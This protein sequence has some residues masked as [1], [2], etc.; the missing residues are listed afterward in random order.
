M[1]TLSLLFFAWMACE[2]DYRDM[3]KGHIDLVNV[4]SS[5]DGTIHAK[6]TFKAKGDGYFLSSGKFLSSLVSKRT[7]AI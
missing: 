1:S 7:H 5:A 4:T 2:L 3:H 6:T